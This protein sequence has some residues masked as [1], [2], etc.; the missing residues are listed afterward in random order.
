MAGIAMVVGLCAGVTY[1]ARD[2]GNRLVMT[3]GT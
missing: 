3:F 2:G 1:Q